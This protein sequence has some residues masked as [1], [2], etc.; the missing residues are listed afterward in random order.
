[1]TTELRRSLRLPDGLAMIVGLMIGSG[2]FRTPGVIAAELGRPWL[3]FVAWSLGGVIALAG[4]LIF[5]EL[6]TRHPRAGGKYVYVREAF[7]P[8]AGFAVGVVEIGCYAAAGAAIT[9]VAGEYASQLA[10]WPASA[11][12]IAGVTALVLFTAI[13]LVGVAAGRLVQNVVTAAKVTAFVGVVALAFA[14]GGGAGWGAALPAAPSG[15]AA[16]IALAVA[17]QAV[18]WT[19]YGY[20]DA[21]K[22][23]EEVVDPQRT[24]PRIFIGSIAVTAALYLL[25]NAAFVHVLPFE[26]LASSR[27]PAHDVAVALLGARGGVV[28]EALALL[29]VLAS[30]NGNLFVT[31]RVVFAIARDGLAP[32]ALARVNRGG[33]PWAAVLLVGVAVLG[34]ALSGTFEQLLGIAVTLLL[35]TD[36]ATALALV[37]LR[38]REPAAAFSVPLYPLV[39]VGFVAV[40]AALLVTAAVAAPVPA[41]VSGGVLVAAALIS[42]V[43]VPARRA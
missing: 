6:G 31:P 7:G 17:F 20:P 9:V 14:G 5:A 33:S 4:A 38:R 13:N 19:Y 29:V 41:L 37:R 11:I 34:L 12:P 43:W 39:V 3:T 30:I 1:M 16:F 27:L 2:I 35:L 28:I 22:V 23:A 42:A 32:A 25:L 21:G 26:T 24:L 10:G 15:G 18:I 8:R 40:Y 36:G